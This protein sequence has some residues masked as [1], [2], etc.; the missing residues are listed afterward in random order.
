LTKSLSAG[1]SFVKYNGD[2][3]ELV[4]LYTR[5]VRKS[6][7]FGTTYEESHVDDDHDKFLRDQEEERLRLLREKELE[8]E[9]KKKIRKTEI[10]DLLRQTEDSSMLLK[11][12]RKVKADQDEMFYELIFSNSYPIVDEDTTPFL[13]R[14]YQDKRRFDGYPP[15]RLTMSTEETRRRPL[16]SYIIRY[17]QIKYVLGREITSLDDLT[18]LVEEF[19]KGVHIDRDWNV[20][21]EKLFDPE[22]E[23]R[24]QQLLDE[25]RRMQEELERQRKEEEERLRRIEERRRRQLEAKLA[26]EAY[27]RALKERGEMLL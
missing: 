7:I 4:K 17:D 5:Q 2:L 14:M 3:E 26:K 21:F 6:A 22:E 19:M 11:T 15:F 12:M 24:K 20:Y 27:L 16:K 8:D 13:M 25:E 10:D 1:K 18:A 23:L 9:R